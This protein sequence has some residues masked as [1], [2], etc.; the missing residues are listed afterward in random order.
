MK[1]ANTYRTPAAKAAIG[2]TTD[3]H[4][5]PSHGGASLPSMPM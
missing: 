4:N 1:R 2:M 5:Q 3:K